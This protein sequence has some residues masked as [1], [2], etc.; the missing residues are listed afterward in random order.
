MNTAKYVAGRLI[1]EGRIRRGQI[2]VAGQNVPLP[3]GGIRLFNLPMETGIRVM[4][5]EPD[6]RG[7]RAGVQEG[8][9]VIG[10]DNQNVSAIDDLHRLLTE[11]QV[12]V[13]GR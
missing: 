12:G 5:V 1:Q 7:E 9:V 10:F 8:D 11:K 13:A 6:S 3:R 2:G 4:S